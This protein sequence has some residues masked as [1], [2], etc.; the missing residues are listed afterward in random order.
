MST[1]TIPIEFSLLGIKTEQFAIFEDHFSSNVDTAYGTEFTF[2]IDVSNKQI[3]VFFE[4]QLLQTDQVIV[5]I[6]VSCHFKLTVSSWESFVMLNNSQLV[7]PK[8]FLAHVAMITLGTSRGIL[9]AKTEGTQVSKF[10]IPILNI[11][12]MIDTDIV[13]DLAEAESDFS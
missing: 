4:F 2:N 1:P 11:E 10:I 7:V 3:G 5:K 12:E 13:F 6:V 9:F 8:G